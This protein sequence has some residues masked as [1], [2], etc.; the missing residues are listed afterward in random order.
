MI[1]LV[2]KSLRNDAFHA[3]QVGA[4]DAARVGRREAGTE[5]GTLCSSLYKADDL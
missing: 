4:A 5:Y 1:G 2:P 3:A